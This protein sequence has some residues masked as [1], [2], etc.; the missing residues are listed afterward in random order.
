M[1]FTVKTSFTSETVGR[2]SLRQFVKNDG[3]DT[4]NTRQEKLAQMEDV[5]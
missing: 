2:A 4:I 3:I 5:M 1:S